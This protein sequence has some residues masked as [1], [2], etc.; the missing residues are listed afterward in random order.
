[1]LNKHQ[2]FASE[3][4]LIEKVQQGDI[5]SILVNNKPV[6]ITL[7]KTGFFAFR[8]Q[9]PHNRVALSD[10]K[11]NMYDEIVCPW[12]NYRFDLKTGNETS[13]NGHHLKTYHLEITDEGVYLTL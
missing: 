11:C 2:I 8:D 9:C 1:M 7:T 4:E 13:G 3:E 6:A 12:H 5:I 10:G